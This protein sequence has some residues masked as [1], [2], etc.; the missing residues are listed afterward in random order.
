MY[1]NR[2]RGLLK[3]ALK[4]VTAIFSVG[5]A[6]CTGRIQSQ[7]E[8]QEEQIFMIPQ[9]AEQLHWRIEEKSMGHYVIKA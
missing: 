4:V 6:A 9:L 5:R 3:K 8:N 1:Y 2:N 7:S